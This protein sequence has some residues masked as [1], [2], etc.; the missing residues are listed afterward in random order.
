MPA[1]GGG[2][3]GGSEQAEAGKLGGDDRLVVVVDEASLCARGCVHRV[4]KPVE[5]AGL[6]DRDTHIA[7]AL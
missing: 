6:R 7:A 4:P 1:L 2:R 3:G 5:E